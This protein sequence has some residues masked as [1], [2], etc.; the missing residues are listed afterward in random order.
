MTKKA[1]TVRIRWIRSTIAC[2][3]KHKKVIAG[4]GFRKLQQEIVRPDTPSIRGMIAK[5]PHLV[6]VVE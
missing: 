4:L 1:G 3:E 5:V 2:P 6:Q